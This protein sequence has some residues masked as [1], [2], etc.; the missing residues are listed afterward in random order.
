MQVASPDKTHLT[1]IG[2]Y[3]FPVHIKLPLT[4]MSEFNME[5]N[6]T[7]LCM[8]GAEDRGREGRVK[9]EGRKGGG[10]GGGGG[11]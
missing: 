7:M 3:F 10:S 6:E 8:W 2:L 5:H 9:R 1:K 4:A 11:E